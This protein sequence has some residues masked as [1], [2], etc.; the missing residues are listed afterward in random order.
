MLRKQGLPEA[1]AHA[2]RC[3]PNPPAGIA[4]MT[5]RLVTKDD[6]VAA[7]K[8]RSMIVYAAPRDTH[9]QQLTRPASVSW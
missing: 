3:V 6:L 5:A 1:L 8:V 7:C 9:K 4:T 2:A